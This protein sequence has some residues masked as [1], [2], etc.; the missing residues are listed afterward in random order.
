[1]N[2]ISLTFKPLMK[3]PSL[4]SLMLL[5]FPSLMELDTERKCR[6]SWWQDG[7]RTVL[8]L[9]VPG[10]LELVVIEVWLVLPGFEHQTVIFP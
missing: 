3:L 9:F 6:S 5:S 1:M 2:A 4:C 8:C 10:W 7:V